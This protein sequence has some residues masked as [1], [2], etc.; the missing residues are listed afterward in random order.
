MVVG[1]PGGDV[2]ALEGAFG[3]GAFGGGPLGGSDGNDL[4]G[5]AEG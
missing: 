5:G 1:E 4:V 3:S 2:V